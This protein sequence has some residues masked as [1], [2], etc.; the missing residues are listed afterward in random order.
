MLGTFLKGAKEAPSFTFTDVVFDA[1]DRSTYTFTNVD[2]GDP[3]ANRTLVIPVYTSA[4]IGV[5]SSV[6]VNSS[7]ATQVIGP[8]LNTASGRTYLY[9]I[10]LSS[11]S[12]AS[13]VVTNSSSTLRCVV[14][15]Y[16]LYGYDS[17]PS[18]SDSA[19]NIDPTVDSVS[20]SL[21]T[22]IG[23]AVIGI[24]QINNSAGVTGTTWSSSFGS[25]VEDY[26]FNP[27]NRFMSAASM[28]APQTGSL[29]VTITS[30]SAVANNKAMAVA[31]FSPL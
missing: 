6:T 15:V 12:T 29:T 23:D 27:E 28:T 19:T 11:G 17:V 7:S 13:I 8:V 25:L 31:S 20:L 10:D 16:A 22:T 1:V 4:G 21:G 9:T 2:I 5:V 26:D 30:T 14:G 24:S 18:A 3:K